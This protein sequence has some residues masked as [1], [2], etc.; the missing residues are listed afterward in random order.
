MYYVAQ[1]F[2]YLGPK[3]IDVVEEGSPSDNSGAIQAGDRLVS[4]NEVPLEDTSTD[5][6][7]QM[8]IDAAR[9]GRVTLEGSFTLKRLSINISFPVEF[10]IADSVVPSSGTFVLKLNKRPN[11]ALGITVSA[12]RN[13]SFG[14]PLLISGVVSGSIA[15]RTGSLSPGDKLIAINQH[16]L[17][18]CTIEDAVQILK[19]SHDIVRLKVSDS[20]MGVRYL[21][22]YLFR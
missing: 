22:L 19:N 13:R 9:R 21:W 18:N 3:L 8:L 20:F 5:E 10:D 17:D 14:E 11:Q 6:A 16:M 12:P 15:H 7:M 1:H 2:Q 4:I